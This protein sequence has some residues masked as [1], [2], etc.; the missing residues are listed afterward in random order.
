[1][2]VTK[3]CRKLKKRTTTRKAAE[4]RFVQLFLLVKLLACFCRFYEIGRAYSTAAEI[5]AIVR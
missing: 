1:M 2:K 5:A 4:K 3:I